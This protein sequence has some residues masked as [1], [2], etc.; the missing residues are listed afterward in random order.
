MTFTVRKTGLSG[1]PLS[2]LPSVVVDTETTGLN[3]AADKVVEIAAIRVE[4]GAAMREADFAALINPQQPIPV[5]ATQIH[6]ITDEDVARA[7][8]FKPV[9]EAFSNWCGDAVVLGY[10]IGFDLG[11]LKAEHERHGM[12]WMAPRSLDVRHLVQVA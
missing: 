8:S 1:L 12:R 9:M 3:V 4:D 10:S 2:V 11:I 6:S 7:Q 5:M